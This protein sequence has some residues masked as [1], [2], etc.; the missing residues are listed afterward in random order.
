MHEF[1]VPR[2]MP[3]TFAIAAIPPRELEFLTG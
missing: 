3:S 2:S 1:V